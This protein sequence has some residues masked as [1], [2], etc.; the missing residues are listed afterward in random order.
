MS[1][2]KEQLSDRIRQAI[3]ADLRAFLE[4]K[5]PVEAEHQ[6]KIAQA[7]AQ[8]EAA[9][10]PEIAKAWKEKA[11]QFAAEKPDQSAARRQ[12]AA[13]ALKIVANEFRL[14]LELRVAAGDAPKS[15]KSAKESGKRMK[16]SEMQKLLSDLL[17]AFPTGGAWIRIAELAEKTGADV[18]DVRSALLRLKREDKVESNGRKGMAGA[19]KRK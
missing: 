1:L 18:S 14:P 5:S 9:P 2:T 12:E 15:A 3:S 11:K 4:Q 7:L 19:W 16:R 17:A 6:A 8:A 10:F 13:L